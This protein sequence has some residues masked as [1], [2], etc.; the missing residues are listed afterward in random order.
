MPLGRKMSQDFLDFNA[1]A[2]QPGCVSRLNIALHRSTLLKLR[3]SP[4]KKIIKDH[5]FGFSNES[6]ESEFDARKMAHDCK[7]LH[8]LACRK[9]AGSDRLFLKRCAD[10]LQVEVA[11]CPG[12]EIYTR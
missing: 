10:S 1:P 12:P 7:Q 8:T 6:A 11:R 5:Q 9:N 3:E 4:V 2:S